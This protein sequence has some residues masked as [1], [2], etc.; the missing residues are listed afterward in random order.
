MQRGTRDLMASRIFRLHCSITQKKKE[1]GVTTMSRAC[2]HEA[3]YRVPRA[4]RLQRREYYIA[5]WYAELTIKKVN[6]E[7]GRSRECTHINRAT[8]YRYVH[9]A[10][11]IANARTRIV[12]I[13]RLAAPFSLSFPRRSRGIN[14]GRS[15]I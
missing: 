15:C 9:I 14:R 8:R 11:A 5:R 2:D 12:K 3:R 6:R 13:D 7:M 10:F 1:N 4:C